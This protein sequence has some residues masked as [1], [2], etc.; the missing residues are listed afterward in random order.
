MNPLKEITDMASERRARTE[1]HYGMPVYVESRKLPELPRRPSKIRDEGVPEGKWLLAGAARVDITPSGPVTMRGFQPR[2]S[3]GIHTRLYVRALVLD[4]GEDSLAI[5]SW[6]KLVPYGFEEIA[7]IRSEIH[8]RT[9]IPVQNILINATHTHSGCEGPFHEA[10]VEAVTQAWKSRRKA[11]IGIG[12]KMIYGIGSN[13]RLPDGR[14][15][16]GCN[17]PN[18][19]AVMDNEC[20]VIRVEDEHRNIIA[21]AF[22]YA[23]HPT[24]L[25][26]DNT[27]LSGDFAGIS[28]TEI[29]RQ[30]GG[31]A[32]AL[33]LQGCAGDVGTHTFRRSRTPPEAERLGK[34][35]ANK[36]LEILQH[37][38]VTRWVRLR[39]KKRMIE[40]PQKQPNKT[41]PKTIPPITGEKTIKNEIQALVIDDAVI[42]AVGSAEAY[43]EIG[44][45][46]KEAS[47]FKHT[48]VLAYSNGPWLGYLPSPHGYAVNDPDAKETP[49][50]PQAPQVLIDEALKLV[51]EMYQG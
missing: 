33:F 35:L 5:L 20:G 16:W 4:N 30:L 43:V 17:Q 25:G 41:V 50:A 9:G 11:R 15:L 47:P 7:K 10:S 29:E 8:E 18:P 51:N 39:G 23:C 19:E 1:I 6:E 27:L 13:R 46:I 44:L 36:V 24:V 3:T 14:G 40:L 37:I 2:Q 38:D 48:F 26:G 21:V 42:L 34:R 49:F 12:S 32:V 31:E 28:M 45:R 22:N